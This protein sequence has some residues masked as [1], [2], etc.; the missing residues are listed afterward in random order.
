MRFDS[1]G[2]RFDIFGTVSNNEYKNYKHFRLSVD[3]DWWE[4]DI[5]V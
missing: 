3:Q 2:F 1:L 5:R 4:N